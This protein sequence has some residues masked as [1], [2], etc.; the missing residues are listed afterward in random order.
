VIKEQLWEVVFK[1]VDVSV[2]A[3]NQFQMMFAGDRGGEGYPKKTTFNAAKSTGPLPKVKVDS[4]KRKTAVKRPAT[5]GSS[6]KVA[7]KP[8]S[9]LTLSGKPRQKPG[10]KPGSKRMPKVAIMSEVA[11]EKPSVSLGDL[12]SSKKVKAAMPT[13]K[14]AAGTNVK[15]KARKKI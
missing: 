3:K 15:A 4:S 5:K 6:K 8:R 9:A 11:G 1:A 12:N 2:W 14:M 13:V 10:P 7:V